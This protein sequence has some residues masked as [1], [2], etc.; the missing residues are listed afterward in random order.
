LS[1]LGVV[2]SDLEPLV[3]R[4]FRDHSTPSNPRPLDPDLLR[5]LYLEAL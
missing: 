4:A 3:E 1:A 2:K 5:K